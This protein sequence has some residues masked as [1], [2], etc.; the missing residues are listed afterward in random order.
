MGRYASNLFGHLLKVD[1][2]VS[3]S[4]QICIGFN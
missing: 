2:V 3:F 1:Y 4:P